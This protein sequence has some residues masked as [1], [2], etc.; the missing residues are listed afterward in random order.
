MSKLPIVAIGFLTQRDL[1]RL[2][3]HFTDHIPVVHDEMFADLLAKLDKI[4]IEPLGP[5][6][7]LRPRQE[8]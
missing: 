7:V 2:G 8:G 3:A 5:A 1:A 6:V 4:E